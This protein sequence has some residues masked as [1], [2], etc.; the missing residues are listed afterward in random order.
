VLVSRS[1]EESLLYMDLQPCP[2]CSTK[3]FDW[4][5]HHL[6]YDD[7]G[8]KAGTV[9]SVYDGPCQECGTARRYEFAL[10]AAHPG[11]E[12]FGGP[13][14]SQIVD[15]GQYLVL[16]RHAAGL[17]PGDP[18]HCPPENRDAAHEAIATAL[19]ALAEVVKFVPEDTDR[20]PADAFWTEQG[21]AVYA[22]DPGQFR[23]DRLDAVAARYARVRDAYGR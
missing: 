21:R 20:V 5:G 19:L 15:P 6:E 11:A 18:V 23:R 13:E 4:S 16:A 17:V 14:P 1:A 8:T 12:G 10:A 2:G 9:I 22:A 3:G 7:A